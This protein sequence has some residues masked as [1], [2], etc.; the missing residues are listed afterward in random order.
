MLSHASVRGGEFGIADG[1]SR[2]GNP[3]PRLGSETPRAE[4]CA[5]RFVSVDRIGEDS[6]GVTRKAAWGQFTAVRH[7]TEQA[8]G[9]AFRASVARGAARHV[10]PDSNGGSRTFAVAN[11]AV[12]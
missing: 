3:S 6:I 11:G 5:E 12:E 4:V 7:E 1:F 8:C 9:G 2:L 10:K